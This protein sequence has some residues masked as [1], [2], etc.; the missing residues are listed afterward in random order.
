MEAAQGNLLTELMDCSAV[1]YREI[2]DRMHREDIKV[3]DDVLDTLE[4]WR[5]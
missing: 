1:N 4:R 2:Y 3:A 5:K